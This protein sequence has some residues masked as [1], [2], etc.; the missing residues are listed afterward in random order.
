MK[1]EDLI[2]LL[3][4]QAQPVPRHAARRALALALLA[5][6]PLSLALMLAGYGL[7]PGLAASLVQQPMALLKL[8]LP[9]LV[10]VAGFV[11]IERLARPGVPVRRAFWGVVLPLL[12]LWILGLAAWLGAPAAER[13]E[14]LWG[15]TWRTCALS[16]SWIALPVFAASLLALR[17]LAPTRPALA[18]AAAGVLAAGSGAAVYALHCPELAAPFLAIWYVLGMAIPVAA[19]AWLGPRVLR[20]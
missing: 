7:R 12:L 1:T 16:I 2:A 5:G 18:G 3:A 17:G 6:L 8:L 19:G 9:A 10:A 15:R 13:P 20:W 4:A 14:L 11:A